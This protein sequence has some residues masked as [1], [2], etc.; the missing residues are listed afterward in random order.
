MDL[1]LPQRAM[2]H[3]Q[4]M[5]TSVSLLQ[6][7]CHGCKV[8][9]S[10]S[11]LSCLQT[12]A[13]TLFC[14]ESKACSEFVVQGCDFIPSCPGGEWQQFYPRTLLL[15]AAAVP[16][17]GSLCPSP[18]VSTGVLSQQERCHHHPCGSAVMPRWQQGP[19]RCSQVHKHFRVFNRHGSLPLVVSFHSAVSLASGEVSVI[20][21][22]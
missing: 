2:R 16:V 20:H 12:P 6:L 17:L 14:S 10:F 11:F 9:L 19:T 18:S 7:S 21:S 1:N 13:P 5:H 3:R 22:L 15:S 8:P 4:V